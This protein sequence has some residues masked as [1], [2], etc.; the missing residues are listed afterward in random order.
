MSFYARHWQ[1]RI[2]LAIPSF[3]RWQFLGA[4]ASQAADHCCVAVDDSGAVLGVMGLNPRPFILNGRPQSAAELTTWVVAQEARG[5][6]VGR[7]ILDWLMSRY[8]V[9]FGP[10][11]TAAALPLYIGAGFVHIRH[12]PRVAQIYRTDVPD[13]FIR[14]TDAGRR[15]L[16][17]NRAAT[18]SGSSG[19][20][21]D[22]DHVAATA[23]RH[24]SRFNHY[25][26]DEAHLKWRYFDHPV[27]RYEFF[28]VVDGGGEAV[29]AMR[30]DEVRDVK[31]AHVVECFGAAVAMPAAVSFLDRC[32]VE[33]GIHIA[34][35]TCVSSAVTC[36]FRAAGWFST[37]DDND[38]QVIN[39]FHP[40][41]FRDPPTTSLV[42]WSR[43][44]RPDLLD[45]G[46]LYLTK[47]DLDLDRPTHAYYERHGLAAPA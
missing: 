35:F 43:R 5:R 47:G 22:I 10:G 19:R 3:Y 15:R 40:P 32:C 36:F 24:L 21:I 6:G 30:V 25:L 42:L 44:D 9:L 33:R 8:E 17:R 16:M 34:D 20:P 13:D 39:L 1:R 7:A 37:I 23:N 18:P 11:I 31:I 41:E 14:V 26:R 4:P 2:A 27:F 28:Q 45:F 29:V 46:R 12:V 38:V